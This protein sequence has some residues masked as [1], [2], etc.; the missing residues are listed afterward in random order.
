MNRNKWFNFSV[1][2]LLFYT[3]TV[4]AEIIDTKKDSFIDK[5]TGLEWLDF[6]IN[7]D[8]SYNEV[9]SLLEI[10]EEYDGWRLA[11]QSNVEA[12]WAN[13]FHSINNKNHKERHEYS[14]KYNDTYNWETEELSRWSNLFSIMG[15]NVLEVFGPNSKVGLIN[16]IFEDSYGYLISAYASDWNLYEHDKDFDNQAYF[17]A[18]PWHD[19]P[20]NH[21]NPIDGASTFL[22]RVPSPELS[23]ILLIGL[24]GVCLSR[25]KQQ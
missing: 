12:L 1:I 7:S 16:G 25:S 5:S 13:T 4:N 14:W 24:C 19:N 22:I 6:G 10:G 15:Y 2:A 8:Y 3:L 23:A 17:K 18:L 20:F 11:T 9:V 21:E